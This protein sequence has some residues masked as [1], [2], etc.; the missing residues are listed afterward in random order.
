MATASDA[1]S[2][3]ARKL[4]NRKVA[5]LGHLLV[6]SCTGL[7]F[8]V[9]TNVFVTA[10]IMSSWGVG[11]AAHG[12][13]AVAAP[14][15]RKR[16]S[17]DVE[18]RAAS[19]AIDERQR[20]EGRHA[21]SLEILSASIAHEIRNPIT[22]ARSLVAQIGEDPGAPENAEYARVALEELDRVERSISHLLRFARD[23]EMK[24]EE[25]SMADVL[26][27][28]LETFQGRFE[29]MGVVVKQDLDTTGAVR[30]DREKMRRVLVNLVG[31]A[32][33]ALE[34]SRTPEPRLEV[35]MGENLA[36]TEVWLRLRDNGPGIP[37]DRLQKIFTPFYTSK[38]NGTGLGLAL[39]R[40]LVEAHGGT[41]GAKSEAGRGAEVTV[42][43]P[44]HGTGTA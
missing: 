23:E 15:L 44:R 10:V 21:R 14:V 39:S 19:S 42:V 1:A 27:S 38:S 28:S 11:L 12:F 8:V 5:F 9:V 2:E 32:L 25:V 34:E 17:R 3:D 29:K 31:N 40:K 4:A 43:L 24:L 16:W 18:I 35:T 33:D 37:P 30:A 22:A 7:F 6:Y 20:I 41:L 13:F 36:G 26:A